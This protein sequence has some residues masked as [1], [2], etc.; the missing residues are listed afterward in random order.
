MSGAF[1]RRGRDPNGRGGNGR[2]AVA[3][4]PL[5][6]S[7][8]RRG[9]R[10]AVLGARGPLDGRVALRRLQVR[11]VFLRTRG[12]ND[13]RNWGDFTS[14]QEGIGFKIGLL[15]FC[16]GGDSCQG[17]KVGWRPGAH[18]RPPAMSADGAMRAREAVRAVG[19]VTVPKDP[20]GGLVIYGAIDRVLATI[21]D[22]NG[23]AY[24]RHG[25]PP[26][27]RS[28]VSPGGPSG[29]LALGNLR[30]RKDIGLLG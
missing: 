21:G 23:R 28:L 24:L 5:G 27:G 13:V 17:P 20:G 3:M 4:R 19:A 7:G 12:K 6:N 8:P 18:N 9:S 25:G 2:K 11:E 10:T 14:P 26:R 29:A 30:V 22:G 16:Q 15:R 1:I